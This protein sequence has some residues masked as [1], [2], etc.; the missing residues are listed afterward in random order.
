MNL[1]GKGITDVFGGLG[2]DLLKKLQ[3]LK[4]GKKPDDMSSIP[5][6]T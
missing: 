3:E 1:G 4:D 6:I 2:F 5:L